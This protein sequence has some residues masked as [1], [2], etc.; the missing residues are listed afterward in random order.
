MRRGQK[1]AVMV[2]AALFCGALPAAAQ[3][4]GDALL[5][6]APVFPIGPYDLRIGGF[7]HGAGFTATQSAGPFRP[8]GYEESGFTGQARAELRL[9]RIYDSGLIVGAQS[10][11]LIVREELS[12]DNYGN[13]TL[14][15]F[16][17]YM[18][19]GLGRVELGQQDG[20][21]YTI[22]VTPPTVDDHVS[23]ENPD[24]VF[25]RD[26]V[27]KRAF[28]EFAREITVVASSSN[29]FKVSYLT[30]RLF[31]AQIGLSYTPSPLKAPLPLLA[32]PSNA[33][34]V[35][36]SIVEVVG[37]YTTRISDVAVG[38]SAAYAHG[39]LRNPTPG[40][41]DI[42]DAALGVQFA[43]DIDEVRLSGGAAYRVSNGYGF[44]PGAALDG[45]ASQRLHT[46]LMLSTGPWRVGAEYS[47]GDLDGLGALPN[48][49]VSGYQ[50]SAGF[51]VNANMQISA[52]W[53]WYDYDRSFGSFYNGARMI[54]MNAGFVTIGYAL[55]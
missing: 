45:R 44:S 10:R 20:A 49:N 23:L 28:N 16:Y 1:H 14:E 52:G 50:L 53:Q 35:Q 11:V 4:F 25:F 13:D 21:A 46:S 29:L 15:K 32:N 6:D 26:P 42:Y 36:A 17:L 38:L 18:Q 48:V 5:I 39:A 41:G 12:G 19:T 34:D 9:Q 27:T 2:A 22:G 31:G 33:P 30:P 7:A 51:A 54:D 37:A 24:S 43:Y 40:H 8:D 55:Q 3:G 47:R